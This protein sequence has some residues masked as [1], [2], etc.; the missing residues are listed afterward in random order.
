M[1]GHRAPATV[2]MNRRC[3]LGRFDQATTNIRRAFQAGRETVKARR[4]ER[5]RH[6]FDEDDEEPIP[7]RAPV[8]LDIEHATTSS[9]DDLEVPPG[10]RVAAAWGWRLIVLGVIVFYA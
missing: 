4:A 8:H 1:P 9:R 10:L 2:W 6:D 5:A 7:V 3:A